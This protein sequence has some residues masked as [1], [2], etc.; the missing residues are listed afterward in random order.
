M[1]VLHAGGKFDDNSYKVSESGLHGVGVSGC[2]C[3]IISY[4]LLSVG[5]EKYIAKNI[6]MEFP[7]APLS[8]V[9]DADSTGTSVHFVPSTEN[10]LQTLHTIMKF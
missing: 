1:T 9:G 6:T 7:V 5:V 8:I 10:T 4:H 3:S 2:K